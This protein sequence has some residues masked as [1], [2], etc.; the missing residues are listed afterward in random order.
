MSYK[1]ILNTLQN[2]FESY[3]FFRRSFRFSSFPCFLIAKLININIMYTFDYAR[4]LLFE[5]ENISLFLVLL[6]YFFV[7][8]TN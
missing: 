5:C 4:V 2:I 3:I 1:H 7:D 8:T 6:T